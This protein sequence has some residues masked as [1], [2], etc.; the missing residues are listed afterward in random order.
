M[1]E[2]NTERS[3]RTR[4]TN[5]IPPSYILHC[6]LGYDGIKYPVT[7]YTCIQE[8]T[9]MKTQVHESHHLCPVLTISRS[10][11]TQQLQNDRFSRYGRKRRSVYRRSKRVYLQNDQSSRYE[12]QMR[13]VYRRSQ[14]VY[15]HQNQSYHLHPRHQVITFPYHRSLL[16][17]HQSQR[18]RHQRMRK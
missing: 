6:S 2:C 8:R 15:L 13:S 7:Q 11:Y 18:D 12:R 9:L 17:H 1:S 5:R 3:A 4:V 10:P 14:R 16:V